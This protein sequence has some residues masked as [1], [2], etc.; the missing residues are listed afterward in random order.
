VSRFDLAVIG[1]GS[2]GLSVAAAAAQFGRRVV[3]FE[4]AQM[5]GDC[6]NT[7]CVPS[8]ALLAAAKAAQAVRGASAFGIAA[9]EPSVD[10]ARVM[11]RVQAVIAAIAPH[12]S[13]ERFEKLG[14]TV[15]RAAARFAGPQVLEAGG[16]RHEARRIVI[17]TGSRPA[18]PP[19][20]G[21][22]EVAFLTSESL[23][24][25]RR[26]PRHLV[27]IGGGPIGLEMAQAHRRLGAAVTVIEA[28]DP[29]GRED[30]ACA[31]VVLDV[32][33]AEGIRVF[34]RTA[35]TAVRRRG[36]GIAVETGGAGVIEGSDLLVATGRSANVEGLDLDRAGIASN[37]KGIIVD[38]GLRTSN[39]A[40]YAIGDVVGGP[41]FTHV[42]GDHAGLVVRSALFGLPVKV[43]T[44]LVPR[45][46][47][48]D[49]ELA[50][51]GLTESEARRQHGDAVSVARWP[52]R[53]NDRAVAD[54]R[55]DGFVKVIVGRRGRILGVSIVGAGAGDLLQPWTLALENG[56]GL[57]AMAGTLV[58]YPTRGE[59]SRRA[60]VGHFAG[61][62]ANPWVRRIIGLVTRFG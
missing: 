53:D 37:A 23:F 36:E 21:L 32:L 38:A 57:R 61:L 15:V 34:P 46:T 28:L 6:L 56:L 35:V 10:F 17:A 43:R 8:K 19:I 1:A 47:F 9:A 29:L 3:L 48:T 40:V 31:A 58:P 13:Q 26:L 59:A 25:N 16:Q 12:D 5:G 7:G 42:A 49:P 44:T 52:F 41:Q 55:T 22:G 50:Q 2:G 4:K 62:A 54:G 39:R 33:K 27:V 45:V 60:A 20:P 24:A 30:P 18:L 14:V 11:D 51:L